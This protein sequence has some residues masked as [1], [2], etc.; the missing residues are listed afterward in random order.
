MIEYFILLQKLRRFAIV[1]RFGIVHALVFYYIFLLITKARS[2]Y[3][4]TEGD[5]RATGDYELAVAAIDF[6]RQYL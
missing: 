2:H 3:S 5:A 6:T 1:H 4:T